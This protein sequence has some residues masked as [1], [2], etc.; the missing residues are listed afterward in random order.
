VIRG[1]DAG[2]FDAAANA[3]G[4][5]GFALVPHVG[6]GIEYDLSSPYNHSA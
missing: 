3:L 4:R 1:E 2:R 6:G 5:D